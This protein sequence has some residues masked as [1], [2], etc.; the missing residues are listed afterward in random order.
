MSTAR[1]T[2]RRWSSASRRLSWQPSQE[3]N[4]K[5]AMR[6]LQRALEFIFFEQAPYAAVGEDGAVLADEV[7]A[8]LAV[9][10]ESDGAFHVAFHGE[11]DVAGRDAPVL[12]ELGDDV[13]HHDFG[14]ADQDDGAAGMQ[15]EVAEE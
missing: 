15:A 12:G 4:L 5:T 2:P 10:A 6:G 11:V 1:A 3:A 8:V 13:A 9:A 14:S 7:G